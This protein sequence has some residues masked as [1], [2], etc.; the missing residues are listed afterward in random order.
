MLHLSIVSQFRRSRWE[1][2]EHV[3][4]SLSSRYEAW[5]S[6]YITQSLSLGLPVSDNSLS[7][8]RHV[9][10]W[11]QTLDGALGG[12]SSISSNQ[13]Q[14]EYCFPPGDESVGWVEE[15][16]YMGL[17][18]NHSSSRV[19]VSKDRN[20]PHERPCQIKPIPNHSYH[21]ASASWR[22]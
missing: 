16:V 11:W 5:R 13:K 9:S 12:K 2:A 15:D 7:L 19:P 22:L 8:G 6:V 21:L 1:S 14:S 3:V 4:C 10:P 17:N 18:W 20:S